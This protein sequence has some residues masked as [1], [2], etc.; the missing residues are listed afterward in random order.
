MEKCL[1]D[2]QLLTYLDSPPGCEDDLKIEEHLE[3]CDSCVSNLDVL[4]SLTTGLKEFGEH[5]RKL[6]ESRKS[7]HLDNEEIFEYINNACDEDRKERAIIHLAGCDNCFHESITMKKTLRQLESEKGIEKKVSIITKFARNYS[8]RVSALKKKV[9]ELAHKAARNNVAAVHLGRILAVSF[10]GAE[11]TET[12][13]YK[14]PQKFPIKDFKVEI[15]QTLTK[16]TKVVIGIRSEKDLTK[17][18]VTIILK[19]EDNGQSDEVLFQQRNAI[20]HKENME[21]N[22]IDSIKLQELEL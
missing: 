5:S 10:K 8:T 14:P 20:I 22:D 21:I 1:S 9:L 11:C 12:R 18:K 16:P 13:L 6:V 3:E 7:E 2:E 15:T 19:E 4:D 17:V